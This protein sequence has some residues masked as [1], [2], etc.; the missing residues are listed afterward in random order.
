MKSLSPRQ[1]HTIPRTSSIRVIL[2]NLDLNKFFM[3]FSLCINID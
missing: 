3:N 1:K 2:K